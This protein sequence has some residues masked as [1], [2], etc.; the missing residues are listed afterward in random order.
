MLSVNQPLALTELDVDPEYKIDSIPQDFECQL[1]FMVKDNFYDCSKCSQSACK[2]CLEDFT[3]RSGK[4]DINSKKYECT[5]C[6]DVN[7]MQPQNRIMFEVFQHLR[8]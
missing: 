4:G 7:V 1:C 8:F 6:H 5:I 2:D 3:K